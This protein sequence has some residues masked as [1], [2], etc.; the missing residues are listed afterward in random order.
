MTRAEGPARQ[1]RALAFNLDP[2][3]PLTRQ[4]RRFVQAYVETSSPHRARR[5]AGFR[6]VSVRDLLDRPA[7]QKALAEARQAAMQQVLP[8]GTVRALREMALL[9]ELKAIGFA[10]ITDFDI[11]PVSGKVYS[12]SGDPDATRAIMQVRRKVRRKVVGAGEEGTPT[13]QVTEDVVIKLWDKVEALGLLAK[14]VGLP[15]APAPV[16]AYIRFE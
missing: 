12:R 15:D 7:V 2:D 14:I 11:D 16:R 4:E 13:V 1:E 3:R 6:R 9:R 5:A 10:D 8:G